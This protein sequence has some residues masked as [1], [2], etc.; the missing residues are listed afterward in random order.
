MVLY[1]EDNKDTSKVSK[2]AYK[3]AKEIYEKYPS[4]DVE[5]L[6]HLNE[7][8]YWRAT[9]EL[10][11]DEPSPRHLVI[12]NAY[13]KPIG[14][15]YVRKIISEFGWGVTKVEAHIYDSPD[16]AKL[17]EPDYIIKRNEYGIQSLST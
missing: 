7:T 17:Y 5:R 9:A 3:Y 13:E 4:E 1:R 6:I 8:F 16:K 11:K 14:C 2:E 10:L 12:A 15:V